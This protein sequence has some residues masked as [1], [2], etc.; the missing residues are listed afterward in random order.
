MIVG[1]GVGVLD[2]VHVVD[3]GVANDFDHVDRVGVFDFVDVVRVVSV[4]DVV[5]VDV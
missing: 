5:D 1:V 3:R 2:K 4:V